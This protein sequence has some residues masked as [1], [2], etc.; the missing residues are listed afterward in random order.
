MLRITISGDSGHTTCKL[1]GKVAGPWV[2]EL[3]QS[4]RTELAGSP[5]LVVDLSGVS[6]VDAAGRELLG[7]MHSRGAKFDARSPFTKGIVEEIMR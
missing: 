1:E 7:R 6:Y 3:E 4:W 5:A 2:A